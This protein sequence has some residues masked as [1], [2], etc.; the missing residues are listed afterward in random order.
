MTN[1]TLPA[2]FA[3][4]IVAMLMWGKVI[5]DVFDLFFAVAIEEATITAICT[6]VLWSIIS[7][8]LLQ[9][10]NWTRIIIVIY[11]AI[12]FT[13]VVVGLYLIDS[14]TFLP[15]WIIQVIGA[16]IVIILL[17][18]KSSNQF[19]RERGKF[20]GAVN[21]IMPRPPLTV[22]TTIIVVLCQML[23]SIFF[24][25]AI[26]E[27]IRE[28]EAKEDIKVVKDNIWWLIVWGIISYNIWKGE[29]WARITLI[30]LEMLILIIHL[31]L[32][33]LAASI[34]LPTLLWVMF[35]IEAIT[36]AIIIILLLTKS[37][38]QFFQIRKEFYKATNALK[39]N[40]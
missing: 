9:G 39:T 35:I 30:V 21:A 22:V 17:F 4:L 26:V 32:L 2:P 40:C 38:N 12:V 36:A 1:I 23:V 13:A 19:F 18:T 31:A 7:Y 34:S 37:S 27:I 8:N 20:Y 28:T 14:P 33:I 25:I 29:K 24:C 5:W 3:V 6:L 16:I 11:Q 10:K 15:R